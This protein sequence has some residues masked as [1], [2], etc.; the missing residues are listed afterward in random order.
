MSAAHVEDLVDL[1]ALGALDAEESAAVRAH[2]AACARCR[3]LLADAEGTAARLALSV[4][5]HRAPASLR[6]RVLAQVIPHPTAAPTPLP[7][8][9]RSHTGIAGAL[10]H[11]NRRWGA[12]AAVVLVV[13]LAG[14]LV[15]AM[16]LQSEVNDLKRENQQ[17]Q[18]TQ[19]DIVLMALPTSLRRDFV[20]TE[21]AG[22]ARGMV[23]W[24]P[25]VGKCAVRVR[26]LPPPEPGT[27]YQ[28]FFEG[29]M[30]PR[31]AGELKPDEDGIAT[32]NFD[33]SKWKGT[34]YRVWVSAVRTAPESET[35]LLQAWLRRE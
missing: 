24:N 33:A 3:A 5:L 35:V 11:F 1:E 20:P 15:W 18:E 14:L 9:G 7:R 23:S 27:S 26:D 29:Q 16:F 10:M 28:V 21:H 19:T 2:A 8:A 4:P 31:P 32:L 13:P 34:E 30:G 22:T 6:E 17:I 12:M 25:D